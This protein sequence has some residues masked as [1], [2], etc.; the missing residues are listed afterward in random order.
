MASCVSQRVLK[1]TVVT[2]TTTKGGE[3][4]QSDSLGV[5]RPQWILTRGHLEKPTSYL[6]VLVGLPW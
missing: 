6:H 2:K 3:P 4:K 1:L 5:L